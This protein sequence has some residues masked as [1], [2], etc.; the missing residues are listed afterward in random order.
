MT[1]L[2][3]RPLTAGEE[4]L[5]ESLPD[6]GLVGFAAF[7]D[8]Y[9]AMARAGQYRPEWTWVALR[10]GVVVARAA[11]WGSETDTAPQ[12]LDWFDF[13]DPAAAVALLQTA[14]LRSQYTLKL[15]VGWRDHPA[16]RHAAES[17]LAAAAAGL[18]PLVERYRYRWTRQCGVPERPGRLQFRPEP[19]DT[20]IFELFRR[21]NQGSL[22]AQVRRTVA[23]SGLDASAQQELD[24]LRWMPSPRE[25]W[26]LAYTPAGELV[27]LSVPSRN[28]NDPVIGYIGVVPEHRGHGY[29]Y[30]LLVE[31]THLLAEQG[32]DRIVAGTDQTNLP[33]AA[34]FARAGYPIVQERIDL[35]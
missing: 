31:A 23:E 2:V 33:M 15:P 30:D 1:D 14:P 28:P 11:W 18:S 5:F 4:E 34:T 27:G 16:V 12:V 29:A 8:T 3:I 35:I 22:D 19:D 13:T 21:V 9:A 17:R 10:A 25:W 7:G 20:R 26:R 24:H 32:V 6:P